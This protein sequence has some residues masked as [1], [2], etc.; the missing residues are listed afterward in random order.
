MKT[1]T[2]MFLTAF[3]IIEKRWKQPKCSLTDKWINQMWYIH[4][5]K[6]HSSMKRNKVMIYVMT[7][8]NLENT[9]PNERSQ[10]QKATCWMIKFIWNIQKGKFYRKCVSDC[11]GLSKLKRYKEWLLM[12]T[13]FLFEMIKYS[14]IDYSDGFTILWV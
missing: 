7:W 14:K 11:L 6:C 13:G 4:T 12:G 5:I 10:M 9:I 1:C 8:N 2:W 3:F